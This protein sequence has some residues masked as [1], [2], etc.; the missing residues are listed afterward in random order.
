M[1][2]GARAPRAPWPGS[3]RSMMSAPAPIA[4]SASAASRTLARNR[5]IGRPCSA[6]AGNQTREHQRNSQL[7]M[8]P[9]PPPSP[10]PPRR[11]A[12]RPSA[13]RPSAEPLEAPKIVA[14][15]RRL[16]PH[17]AELNLVGIPVRVGHDHRDGLPVPLGGRLPPAWGSTETTLLA[18]VSTMATYSRLVSCTVAEIARVIFQ[19]TDARER[20]LQE[21][22][23]QD[24]GLA[25]CRTSQARS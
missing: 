6:M 9:P 8:P 10:P 4:I 20:V 1:A 24:F 13:G 5:V 7:N 19:K 25:R 17:L 22:P 18:R 11:A 14:G 16:L 3:F 15:G 2:S 23:F 12:R 21:L